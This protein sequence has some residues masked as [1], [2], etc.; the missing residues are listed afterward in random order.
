MPKPAA[1]NL[2]AVLIA[3]LT[4]AAFLLIINPKKIFEAY[5]AKKS[6]DSAP[7]PSTFKQL[8]EEQKST[9]AATPSPT[10]IPLTFEQMNDKYGPCV[11]SSVLMY[12]HIQKELTEPEYLTVTTNVFRQQMDYLKKQGRVVISLGELADFFKTGGN[13]PSKSAALTFD[14]GYFDFF[15][16]A[17]PILKELGLKATVFVITDE[18]N[19][20]GY[21]TWDVIK[22]INRS[23]LINFANHTRDH[24]NVG[25]DYSA[26]EQQ[27]VIA[28]IALKQA[29]TNVPK[30]FSYPYGITSQNA[31][32]VLEN[33]N[34]DLAFTTQS[35]NI[36]CQGQRLALPRIR[37]G[38]SSLSY[39]EL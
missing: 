25:G 21:L 20:P 2:A 31:I 7:R 16:E 24:Q 13:T 19:Q 30:I 8:V 34:Y 18:V 14:D 11:K 35:G 32:K 6:N 22:E 3:L 15:T 1:R 37:I 33:L 17:F 10:P 39:Y 9:P 27:I 4:V 29:N 5:R 12:H 26:V 28:D 23:G 38:N 36:L